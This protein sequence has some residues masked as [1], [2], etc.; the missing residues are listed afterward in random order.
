MRTRRSLRPEQIRRRVSLQQQTDQAELDQSSNTSTTKS[1][2]KKRA[3]KIKEGRSEM[4]AVLVSVQ[5]GT[6]NKIVAL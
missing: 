2:A 5:A 3:S 6:L 4:D 1:K